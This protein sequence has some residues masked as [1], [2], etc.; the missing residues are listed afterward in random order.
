MGISRKIGTAA[1]AMVLAASA[2]CAQYAGHQRGLAEEL[3]ATRQQAELER[4]RVLELE[5][6]LAWLEQNTH[7]LNQQLDAPRS[8]RLLLER[9]DTLIA[10]NQRLLSERAL[11]PAVDPA[12]AER[13]QPSSLDMPDSPECNVG[14]NTEEKIRQ[15]VMRLRG[16]RSPW[17]VDGLSYEESEALRFL[18]RRERQLDAKNPWQ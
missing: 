2:G 12:R 14:L 13:E 18:L 11:R 16:E 7:T 9:L 5:S 4:Q 8:E 1:C 15:L 6:R 10:L 17:R 3:R